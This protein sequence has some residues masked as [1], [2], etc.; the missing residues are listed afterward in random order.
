MIE[1]AITRSWKL[2]H[3][4]V[5]APMAGIAGA[6]LAA[7][8]SSAGGLGML[9]VGS[10]TT[11]DWIAEQAER[12]HP[13]GRFGIGLMVWALARRPE[14]LEAAIAA[15]PVVIALSFGDPAPYVPRVH[16]AGIQVASLVQNA[17]RAREAV[18]AGVDVLVAQG[19]E[20]GGHTGAV[21][22]LPLLQIAL[23][24]GE[25]AGLPVLAAGGIGTG[26]G[27]AGVLAMG[28]A[29]AWIGTRFA[30]TAEAL[31]S[32]AAKRAIVA[33]D[34]TQTVHTHVFDIVQ[35]IP[36]PES[37]PGRALRNAFTDRWHG[38]ERELEQQL[39]AVQPAFEA[40]RARGDY[41]EANIYAGQASG[42]VDDQPH[43]AEL[44]QRL[45]AE[46]EATLRR[47]NLAAV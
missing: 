9:G 12:V 13:H 1:T 23:P 16:A 14:L 26:R 27:I 41:A 43:A 45:M 19:T 32:E 10:A 36:W 44:L 15:R 11:T 39:D 33:A 29:G 4:L 24:I 7:A 17:A 2:K 37:F 35:R 20:A 3:P 47:A 46:A 40:A 22:T 42:L 21:G 28:A 5:Q 25:A 6:D 18:A 38:R 30:A 8:I 31:G 34:E